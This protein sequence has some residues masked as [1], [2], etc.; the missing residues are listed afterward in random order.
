MHYLKLEKH[1]KL[2]EANETKNF[3]DIILPIYE[4]WYKKYNDYQTQI[5]ELLKQGNFSKENILILKQQYNITDSPFIEKF[6][7]MMNDYLGDNNGK[8]NTT[9]FHPVDAEFAPIDKQLEIYKNTLF[10]IQSFS[11]R[12]LPPDYNINLIDWFLLNEIEMDIN[13]MNVTHHLYN[14]KWYPGYHVYT[15][16]DE[17]LIAMIDLQEIRNQNYDFKK[18]VHC[19]KVFIQK[20]GRNKYCR[21][22]SEKYK[23][24][25]DQKRKETP[26]G[27]HKIVSNYL[28]NAGCFS[29][30]EIG[31]FMRES[32]YYWDNLQGKS[33]ER[34]KTFTSNISTEEEYVYWLKKCHNDFKSEAK[35][36]K[37]T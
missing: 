32:N 28:R 25:A 33:V 20:D 4:Y 10:R 5:E 13:S 21:E 26:R 24:I 22:C 2:I 31:D 14:N 16:D 8:I 30:I 1:W 12:E 15:S 9:R 37:H 3:G 7:V 35:H 18:C 34:E 27:K 17:V 29:D 11:W 36:R 23:K 19:G 6:L